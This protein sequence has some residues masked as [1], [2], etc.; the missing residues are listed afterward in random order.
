MSVN[1]KQNGEL[2]KIANNISVV[3]ADWNDKENTSKVSCIRNQP[4]TLK[5]LNEISTNTDENALAG[6]TSV[7]ELINSLK[8]KSAGAMDEIGNDTSKYI[9]IP[10]N[11]NEFKIVVGTPKDDGIMMEQTFA[12]STRSISRIIQ[13][14]GLGN[15]T[16]GGHKFRCVLTADN[17]VYI[18]DA[19]VGATSTSKVDIV[20]MNVYYR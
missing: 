8:W 7:K 9:T 17:K 20:R 4:D 1:V 5:T 14:G 6:A 19:Y 2:V 10:S 18:Q 12:Q 13:F 11:C 16:S 15:S 3:Q